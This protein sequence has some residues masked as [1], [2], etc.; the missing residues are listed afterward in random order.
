[1]CAFGNGAKENKKNNGREFTI[2][3][4]DDDDDCFDLGYDEEIG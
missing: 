3:L 2:D 4:S 1:L